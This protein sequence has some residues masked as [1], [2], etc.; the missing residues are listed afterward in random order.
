[1]EKGRTTFGLDSFWESCDRDGV[2][3]NPL[4]RELCFRSDAMVRLC[5]QIQAAEEL[6]DDE[7]VEVLSRHYDETRKAIRLLRDAILAQNARATL[8]SPVGSNEH[9]VR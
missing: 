5:A 6:G 1:M 3:D 4:E 2:G 9:S 7:A 8:S